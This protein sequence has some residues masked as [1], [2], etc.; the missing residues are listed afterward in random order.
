VVVD[1]GITGN[2]PIRMFDS[3]KYI[4]ATTPVNEFIIN[5]ETIGLRID[6]DEQISKDKN[7]EKT[8]APFD[9]NS[10]KEYLSAF[11]NIIMENL[12]RQTLTKDDWSRTISI[13]N[14]NIAPRIRKMKKQEIELLINNGINGFDQYRTGIF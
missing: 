5:K 10:L 7:N 1:G 13:S 12:N 11:Y 9:V 6:T 2:F 3:T 8:L 14:G 4:D